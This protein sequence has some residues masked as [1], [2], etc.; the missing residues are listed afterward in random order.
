MKK[1]F[2]VLI[3]LL[4]TGCYDYNEL[5]DL[6]IVSS[7]I[8]DYKDDKYVVNLE[9]LETKKDAPK[10][11]FFLEGCG[12][13]FEE[14]LID[15]YSKTPKHIY[16]NH[17][18]AVVLSK[19]IAIDKFEYIYDF[20]LIDNDVRKD[21]VFVLIDDTSK[22]LKFETEDKLSIGETIKSVF[23]Y[24]EIENGNYKTVNF[25]NILNAD[26]NKKTYCLTGISIDNN[27]ISLKDVY[28]VDENKLSLKIDNKY[29]LFLNML[30]NDVKSF[31]INI[32]D[33]T[34]EVYRYKT[35]FSLKEN[36]AIIKVNADIRLF[37]KSNSP[38]STKEDIK[39]LE[40]KIGKYIKEYINESL[41]YSINVDKDIYNIDYRFYQLNK[42][43]YYKGIYK[44]LKYD[45]KT[46]VTFNEKG[47]LL[48]QLGDEK[49]E[50]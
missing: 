6:A 9:I 10:T 49:S 31:I 22:L 25:R 17:I 40:S 41:K 50:R 47:L 48:N 32:D 30:E 28:L 16:F 29:I 13:T 33:E 8:I 18:F 12:N 7:M 39:K 43:K 37:G 19:T 44:N 38:N 27:V 20:F 21:S 34:F 24:S 45:I 11:S 4:L 42:D 15:T 23:N 36:Q 5:T 3:I 46:D 14:A 2:I 35:D 26:L 1:V